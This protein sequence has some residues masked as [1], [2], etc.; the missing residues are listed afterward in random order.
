M[1]ALPPITSEGSGLPHHV[2]GTGVGAAV[3]PFGGENPNKCVVTEQEVIGQPWHCVWTFGDV[4]I[5][6][7]RMDQI[8]AEFR[9]KTSQGRDMCQ[10]W[11]ARDQGWERDRVALQGMGCVG[12]SG[13]QPGWRLL[14]LQME[15]SS[16]SLHPLCSLN[17]LG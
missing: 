1:Y 12:Q 13:P 17:P 15:L 11:K 2:Q 9:G 7:W 6:V 5:F 10:A 4:V 16:K 3:L 14:P 8:Q